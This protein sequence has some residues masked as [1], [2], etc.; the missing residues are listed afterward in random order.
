MKSYVAKSK[1]AKKLVRLL[2]S[3]TAIIF[4]AV[5]LQIG[6]LLLYVLKINNYST[7]FGASM[8]IISIILIVTIMN[9]QENPMYQIAWII[10]IA[11]IPVFG[12]FFYLFVQMQPTIKVLNHMMQKNKIATKPYLMQNHKTFD[13]LEKEDYSVAQLAA[14]MNDYGGYPVYSNTKVTYFSL[15][16][17]KFKDLLI[18]LKKA[19]KFIFLEYF[20]VEEGVMWNQILSILK[21]K[22]KQGVEVRFMYDGMCS[23]TRLPYN[24]PK[25][26][27]EYGIKC[28][29]FN[30]VRPILSTAQNNRDH[31]KILVIDGKV[32]YNGGVNL[33]DEYINVKE[34]FGHWKDT[35]VKIEGEAVQ[36][37]LLMFLEMWNLD[38]LIQNDEMLTLCKKGPMH[39]VPTKSYVMPYGDSPL[40][41]E[42]V[43]E[44][45]YLHMINNAKKYVHIMTPYLIIDNEMISALTFAAK[46]GVDVHIIMPHIPDKWYAF[47]LA[48]TYYQELIEAGVK[49]SEYTDG[50]VHAKTFVVDD[51]MSVVGTINLDYRSFYLHFECATFFYQSSA[52]YDI[53]RDF[54]HLLSKCELAT[55]EMCKKE[56]IYKK[57][58]GKVLRLVAPLM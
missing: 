39:S 22:V 24:Y 44:L 7:Y 58:I 20:I 54:E 49:I 48:K 47:V 8:H 9:R 11:A 51:E 16:E 23:L 37:F 1:G 30:Q 5:L 32:A 42:N 41:K 57:V 15:G 25:K 3:R 10:P 40:D 55:V 34:R 38:E 31:R 2:F 26:M 14:Y 46:R 52:V 19:E 17:E 18:E 21:E 12:T 53:E 56:P 29:I 35:A 43:G 4:A 6:F 33:A 45:V 50:F 13:E 27:K 28:K 36:S